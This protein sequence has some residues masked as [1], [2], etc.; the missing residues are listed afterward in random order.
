MLV[1]HDIKKFKSPKILT[2]FFFKV[3]KNLKKKNG[4]DFKASHTVVYGEV[5]KNTILGYIEGKLNQLSRERNRIMFYAVGVE[6]KMKF[7]SICTF[8]LHPANPTS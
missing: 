2:K 4:F 6:R 7:E 8:F 3:V 5:N 1:N